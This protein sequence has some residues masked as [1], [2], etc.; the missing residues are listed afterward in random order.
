[1]SSIKQRCFS[2]ICRK[3][4][5]ETC[6]ECVSLS[7]IFFIIIN[8]NN[9]RQRIAFKLSLLT[10]NIVHSF[11]S[12]VADVKLVPLLWKQT[13]RLCGVPVCRSSKVLSGFSVRPPSRRS[14]PTEKMAAER[15]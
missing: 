1:M 11:H 13:Q 2:R 8:Y 4:K 6:S 7:L 14:D 9:L 12:I 3:Q 15:H 10:R 5:R